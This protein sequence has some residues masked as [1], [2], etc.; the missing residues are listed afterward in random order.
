[1]S[2]VPQ[3]LSRD[4]ECDYLGNSLALTMWIRITIWDCSVVQCSPE[5]MTRVSIAQQCPS[6]SAAEHH[7][8][9]I[10]AARMHLAVACCPEGA[11]MSELG[12]LGAEPTAIPDTTCQTPLATTVQ[13]KV[14]FLNIGRHE[15][16]SLC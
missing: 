15:E 11:Y 12:S 8:D 6:P 5:R 16:D 7:A 9:P 1:M 2:A 4:V 3:A 14:L 13:G 10:C